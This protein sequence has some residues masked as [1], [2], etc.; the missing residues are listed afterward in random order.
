MKI[1]IPEMDDNLS[2]PKWYIPGAI[3]VV[4]LGGGM[5]VLFLISLFT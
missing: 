1:N 2:D 4:V 5:F 3:L